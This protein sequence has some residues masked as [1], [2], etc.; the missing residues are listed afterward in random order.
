MAD[1][2]KTIN[3][4][5]EALDSLDITNKYRLNIIRAIEYLQKEP[6]SDEL[7]KVVEEIVDP[8][9]LNAYGVKEIANRLRRTMIE[10]VSEELEEAVDEYAPDF[11]NSIASKAAVDAVRD[12]FTSGA[13]W[14]KEHIW[15]D[16][17]GDDLPIFDREVIVF[18]QPYP[19][20]GT[21]YA[22][23]FAPRPNPDGWDGKSLTSGKVEHYT[24][25]TYDKGGW[26]QSDVKW[27]L[28]VELPKV[29]Q[30]K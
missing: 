23:S 6:V 16:A 1:K 22:V 19:L 2:E 30:D 24:P 3:E 12:A 26:N 9:V 20:E 27:W 17:Q 28:D 8:T 10:S 4:L 13:K 14:Q 15:K 25:K 11:S 18:T 21:E 5:K 7:E 29:M